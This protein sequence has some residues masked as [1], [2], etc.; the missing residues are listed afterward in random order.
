MLLQFLCCNLH[1]NVFKGWSSAFIIYLSLLVGFFLFCSSFSQWLSGKESSCQCRHTVLIPE[2]GRSPGEG[3]SNPLKCSCLENPM[4]RSFVGHSPWGR[5]RVR[6]DLA[7]E[8]QQQPRNLIQYFPIVSY[9]LIQ[10]FLFHLE[11]TVKHSFYSK[12]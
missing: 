4:D 1:N 6:H 9:F 3:N 5:K 10:P 2:L 8:Q 12:F 7:T 11:K